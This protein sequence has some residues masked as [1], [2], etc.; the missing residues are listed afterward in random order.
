M[1]SKKPSGFRRGFYLLGAL[2]FLVAAVL[3]FFFPEEGGRS[4]AIVYVLGGILF[5][6]LARLERSPY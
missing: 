4:F 3:T 5:T 1:S 2:G 6:I